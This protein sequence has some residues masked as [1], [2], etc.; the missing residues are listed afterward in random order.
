M[1]SFDNRLDSACNT[2]LTEEWFYSNT[3]PSA[4]SGTTDFQ[5]AW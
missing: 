1:A 2:D 5:I 3:L 4:R